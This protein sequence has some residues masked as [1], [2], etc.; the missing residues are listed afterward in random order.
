MQAARYK[1]TN[2]PSSFPPREARYLLL[3][4]NARACIF[5]LW[6]GLRVY[7]FCLLG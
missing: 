5:T 3:A 6:R 1:L 4:E 7:S 2:L